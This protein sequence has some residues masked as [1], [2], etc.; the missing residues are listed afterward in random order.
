MPGNGAI[1]QVKGLGRQAMSDLADKAKRL[2]VTPARYV[3]ELV[4]QDLA[5]DRKAQATSLSQ[6]MGPGREV[7]EAE[8]DRAVD[9][10]RKRYHRKIA[11]KR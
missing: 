2:G 11:R 7:D 1:L 8:L 3:R 9:E 4:R 10:A 6:L 5:L